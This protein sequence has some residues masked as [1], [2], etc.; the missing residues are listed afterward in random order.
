MN[1]D[2]ALAVII[3]FSAPDIYHS[4]PAHRTDEQERA[5]NEAWGLVSRNAEQTIKRLADKRIAEE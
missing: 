1:L 2:E 4:G 3:H 5:Y